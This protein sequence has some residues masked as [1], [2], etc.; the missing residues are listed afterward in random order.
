MMDVTIGALHVV[1]RAVSGTG[2]DLGELLGASARDRIADALTASFDGDEVIVIRSLS[3]RAVIGLDQPFADDVL[4]RTI[5]A[6]VT[7]AV[8]DHPFDDDEVVRFPDT[9]DYL[10]TYLHDCRDGLADRWY[11]TPLARFRT[12]DG[13]V[14]WAGLLS[15]HHLHRWRILARIDGRGDLEALLGALDGDALASLA[16]GADDGGASLSATAIS[17]VRAAGVDLPEGL[18]PAVPGVP[19]WRDPVSLGGVLGAMVRDLLGGSGADGSGAGGSGAGG[20]AVLE[21]ARGFDWFD[22]G[23]FAE[24][25]SAGVMSSS[26]AGLAESSSS[27]AAVSSVPGSAGSTLA[28]AAPASSTDSAVAAS[29]L[30]PSATAAAISASSDASVASQPSTVPGTSGFSGAADDSTSSDAS[31]SSAASFFSHAPDASASSQAAAASASSLAADLS[32]SS[33]AAAALASSRAADALASSR[34]ADASASGP[35]ASGYSLLGPPESAILEN[36]ESAAIRNSPTSQESADRPPQ[37]SPILDIWP[38]TGAPE[39]PRSGSAPAAPPI[40]Q[41]PAPIVETPVHPA[42]ETSG[43]MPAPAAETSGHLPAPVA[44]TTA[45][46]PTFE[47]LESSRSAG[48]VLSPR[49][50]QVLADLVA[51]VERDGRLYL[52][53]ADPGGA[54]NVIRLVA[55]LIR[56]APRWSEDEHARSVAA[57]VLRVWGESVALPGRAV[58]EEAGRGGSVG[59]A[60]YKIGLRFG[61]WSAS[62]AP[63]RTAAGLLLF[64]TLRDLGLG[65]ALLRPLPGPRSSDESSESLLTALLRCWAGAGVEPDPLVDFVAGLGADD[66][67]VIDFGQVARRMIGQRLVVGPFRIVEIAGG[68]VMVGADERILPLPDLGVPGNADDDLLRDLGVDVRDPEPEDVARVTAA[69]ASVD[70]EDPRVALLAVCCVQVWGRWLPGFGNASAGF[71]LYRLVRRPAEISIDGSAIRV[72]MP[73]WPH[74]IVLKLAGYLDPVEPP[75]ILGGRGIRFD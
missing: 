42:A 31:L 4:P 9:A 56:Y 25:L 55:A 66:G 24:A 40:P 14:D 17:L 26:A 49:T 11:Y 1:G 32:A 60:S 44:E 37:N 27:A 63:S 28:S 47:I 45:H 21:V 5:T 34:A 15:F 65:A 68:L 43:H 69:L 23:A 64:R 10:A 39:A 53:P 19:D 7:R 2:L 46:P 3:C 74:D 41:P 70:A 48:A 29:T 35:A 8:V 12:V 67:A 18:R 16:T 30:V 6:A 61:E 75:T 73:S 59:M 33:R 22:H 57:R 54:A 71:L 20:A 38:P 51:V 58:R 52:D 62:F 13:T 36:G 72:R 50:R